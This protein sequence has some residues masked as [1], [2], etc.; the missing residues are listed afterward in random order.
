MSKFTESR[1]A[2]PKHT[3]PFMKVLAFVLALTIMPLVEAARALGDKVYSG[4]KGAIRGFFGF[5]L[6]VGAGVHVAHTSGWAPDGTLWNYLPNWT[7]GPAAYQWLTAG[8]LATVVT[9][10]YLWP[11]AYLGIVK[12]LWIAGESYWEGVQKF[13]STYFA[14][15][16]QG[17]IDVLRKLPFANSAWDVVLTKGKETWVVGLLQLVAYFS[18]LLSG[19]YLGWKTLYAVQNLVLHYFAGGGTVGFVAGAVVGAVVFLGFT[20]TVWELYKNGKIPFFSLSTGAA[21][22]YLLAGHTSSLV[23]AVGLPSVAVWAAFALQYVLY[24]A[25][26]FPIVNVILTNGFWKWL[27]ETVIKPLFDKVYDDKDKDYRKFFA[28]VVNFVALWKLVALT[29]VIAAGLTLPLWATVPLVAVLAFLSYT[30]VVK[31]IDHEGGTYILGALASLA[32]GWFMGSAYFAVGAWFGIYGAIVCGV[33][34]VAATFCVVF[35][36]AYLAVKAI[37]NPVLASWLSKPL[38]TVHDHVWS[39]MKKLGKELEHA[40]DNCYRDKTPYRELFVHVANIGVTVA[41]GFSS[42][43]AANM[44]GFGLVLT[45]GMVALSVALGYL[46]LGK[47]LLHWGA[48]AVATVLGIIVAIYVGALVQGVQPYGLWVGVPAGI[49]AWLAVDV[50]VFPIVYIIVKAVANPLLTGWLR[51]FLVSV[52]DLAWK[53]FVAFWD[54]FIEM[55]RFVKKLLTPLWNTIASI[56]MSVW[57]SV[58]EVY[59]SIRG[60]R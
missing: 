9:F 14:R 37:A 48:N 19:G 18:A 10:F 25:Y 28:H 53:G 52:Y 46:L 26:V 17:I 35:P 45:V 29:L 2:S 24:N 60:K 36:V 11:I 8:V 59:E 43:A 54:L 22:I 4:W 7:H 34:S 21:V 31:A 3:N 56:W 5:L 16:T 27:T 15:F 13:A 58:K 33:T 57:R 1:S 40:Y 23:A 51:P 39:G 42:L 30:F 20:A 32:A 41:V 44:L 12:P 47:A 55:Y 38:V 49:L 6:A 50:L